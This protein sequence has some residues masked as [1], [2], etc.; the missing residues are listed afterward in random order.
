MTRSRLDLV[1]TAALGFLTFLVVHL[2]T[3]RLGLSDLYWQVRTGEII[4]RTGAIP[5]V[6][7]FSYTVAGTP[8]NNHEWGFELF[9]ALVYQAFGW[10]GFRALTFAL[11]SLAVAVVAVPVAR[12]VGRSWAF[13][14]GALVVALGHYKC[15]PAPQLVSMVLFLTAWQWL[16][17]EDVLATTP[18]AL[19]LAVGLALWA[20]VTAEVVVF[21]PFLVWDQ[22]LRALEARRA[23]VIASRRLALLG[24]CLV[25]PMFTP[26]ASSAFEYALTG[27]AI[28]RAVN[29]EF[30]HLWEP[31]VTVSEG[32]KHVA[33]I[34]AALGAL[35]AVARLVR[36]R[37]PWEERRR[38]GMGLLAVAAALLFER[39]L[40]LLLVPT[41][42]AVEDLFERPRDARTQAA[43]DG[44][45]LTAGSATLAVFL[46][47]IQ[48]SPTRALRT[49][50]SAPY[51]ASAI[52]E[53]VVP[54]EC[55]AALAALPVGA[56]VFTWRVWANYVIWR[57]PHVRV[58]IDGRN[59]EYPEA[60]HHASLTA[61]LGVG[62]ALQILDES[63]TDVVLES[64]DWGARAAVRGGPWQQTVRHARCALYERARP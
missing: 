14:T 26:P 55:G 6:D 8:W 1:A 29:S 17:R 41:L 36:P 40:W 38:A 27:S 4:L 48:W 16:R 46:Q 31:A 32:V 28:N 43:L 13:L 3:Q 12:R 62:R 21:L 34:V 24:L 39:N 49:L 9:A 52:N 23:G 19:G 7:P 54:I 47:G 51:W 33:R 11:F 58:F 20:N 42:L 37:D 18:R 64:P 35:G 5:S 25:A 2:A 22:S 44:L 50:G 61:H 59:R 45:A 15:V 53:R 60:L 57:A 10:Q 30:T 56:R 63:G